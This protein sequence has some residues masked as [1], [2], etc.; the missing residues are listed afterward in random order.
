[1]RISAKGRYALAAMIFMV[2]HQTDDEPIT[3]NRISTELGIS[4]IYLEQVFALL[5]KGGFVKSVKGAQGGYFLC[6]HITNVSCYDVLR[7]VEGALFEGAQER[8]L[9]KAPQV[10]T[11]INGLVIEKADEAVK[12]ALNQVNVVELAH[13]A[14]AGQEPMYYI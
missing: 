6:E 13:Q 9:E 1:M 2:H 7:V 11:V 10:D 14:Q 3:V 4:K 8:V 5:K 12:K